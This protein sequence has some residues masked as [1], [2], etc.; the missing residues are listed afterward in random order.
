MHPAISH[1]NQLKLHPATL[2]AFEAQ[3]RNLTRRA[4]GGIPKLT[5]RSPADLSL[6]VGCQFGSR[7]LLETFLQSNEDYIF[8]LNP[9]KDSPMGHFVFRKARVGML[10]P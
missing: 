6:R 8:A 9:P 5:R 2:L 10:S 7:E 4:P 3:R 1:N